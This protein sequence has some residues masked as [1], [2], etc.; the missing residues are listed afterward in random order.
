MSRKRCCQE[1]NSIFSG[2]CRSKTQNGGQNRIDPLF[3]TGKCFPFLNVLKKCYLSRR[4][5]LRF[6]GDCELVESVDSVASLDDVKGQ[7][8]NKMQSK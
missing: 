8:S 1:R 5:P 6:I 2:R 4:H 7:N 3:L